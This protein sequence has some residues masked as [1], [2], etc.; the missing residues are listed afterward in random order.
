MQPLYFFCYHKVGTTLSARIACKIAALFGWHADYLLGPISRV[1]ASKQIIT[2]AH[3][4]IEFNLSTI[5]HKGV[6]LI[7][8][9]RDVWLSGY[10]YHQ[11]CNERWCTNEC[12]DLTPPIVPPRIP[13]SQHYR[14]EEWKR[15]YLV[16]LNGLSYQRNLLSKDRDSGLDFEMNRYTDWTIEAMLA[17]KPD[18][19][20]IDVK[21]EDFMADFDGTLTL[22]LRHFG[23]REVDI[24]AALTA[25]ASEDIARMNDAEI[26]ANPNIYSRSI[27]KWR[28]MLTPKQI[29]HFEARYAAAIGRL[30]YAGS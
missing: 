9:P 21:I 5:P 8:D 6:R 2:F 13:Y 27:S 3:S 30:G 24:P 11:H 25:L 28:T 29:Q 12:F 1:D 7:R 15:A 10:L 17:W 26:A 23:I 22:M 14:S 16:G 4:L 19:D 18:P 20:T